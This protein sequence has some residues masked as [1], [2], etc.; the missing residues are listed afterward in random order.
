[1]SVS[2]GSLCLSSD[3]VVLAMAVKKLG[4]TKLLTC[5]CNLTTTARHPI[6]GHDLAL[7]G[8]LPNCVLYSFNSR[9]DCSLKVFSSVQFT[10]L[11]VIK[12]HNMCVESL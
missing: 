10:E 2:G 4:P 12:S 1:M 3:A 11:Y 9:K 7:R 6:C 5:A 8:L